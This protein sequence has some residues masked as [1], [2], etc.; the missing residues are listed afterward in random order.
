MMKWSR[1]ALLVL[2]ASTTPFAQ[3]SDEGERYKLKREFR[4]SG[5]SLD[6]SGGNA[7]SEIPFD[8]SYGQ[9]TAAQQNR[10]KTFYVALGDGDEPPF[11][12]NGLGALYRP[13]TQGQQKLLVSGEFRADAEI[14]KDGNLVAVAVLRSPNEEVT[15]FMANILLLTKFKPALCQ[16]QPCSMGFPVKVSFKVE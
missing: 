12:L 2:L 6:S 15:K 11:P 9:L 5:V 16:G 13:V 7:V 14:D 10:F 3:G 1:V 8:K 4:F